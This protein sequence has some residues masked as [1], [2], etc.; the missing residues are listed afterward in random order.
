MDLEKKQ[1]HKTSSSFTKPASLTCGSDL[2][3]NKQRLVFHVNSIWLAAGV[4]AVLT[5]SLQ[6]LQKL[7]NLL[8][9][10][11]NRI[12][13]SG[14]SAIYSRQ[15]CFHCVTRT[16][17]VNHHLWQLMV[18]LT[19]GFKEMATIQNLLHTAAKTSK[20]TYWAHLKKTCIYSDVSELTKYFLTN[21]SSHRTAET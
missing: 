21:W 4:D 20:F 11:E 19:T 18:E 17:L 10:I 16:I 15:E 9:L 2:M 7:K 1:T 8:V 14:Y 5:L 12:P 13:I 6:N 3:G